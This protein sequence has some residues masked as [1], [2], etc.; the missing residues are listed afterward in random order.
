MGYRDKKP[1]YRTMNTRSHGVNYHRGIGPDSRHDRNT[2]DGLRKSMASRKL[3]LDFRPLFLFLQ[4]SVGKKWDDVYSEAKSR[5]PA[6]EAHVIDYIFCKDRGEDSEYF[7]INDNCYFS[8]LMVDDNGILQKFS[9]LTIEKMYPSCD[10]CTHSFN[11]KKI[12][13]KWGDNPLVKTYK[14]GLSGQIW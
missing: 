8:R 2:K 1:L 12:T 11:G 4:S 13:N 6:S 3:G 14:D 5:I 7:I 9:D 10:C